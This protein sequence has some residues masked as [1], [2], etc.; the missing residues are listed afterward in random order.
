VLVTD[1]AAW[2]SPVPGL[3]C[4]A[5]TATNPPIWFASIDD[6]LQI[7][8]RVC[9]RGAGV[10][11]RFAKLRR[12][13]RFARC[14]LLQLAK[15]ARVNSVSRMETSS[16]VSLDDRVSKT[17]LAK[18]YSATVKRGWRRSCFIKA[19]KAE[20]IPDVSQTTKLSLMKLLP[21]LIRNI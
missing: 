5:H 7:P 2:D 10:S 3:I 9:D 14:R 12:R 21:H 20:N 15:R 16:W 4:K 11:G 18:H 6:C 19:T 8:W 13:L 1:T 17:P